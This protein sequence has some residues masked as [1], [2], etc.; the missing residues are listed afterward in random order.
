VRKII[1]IGEHSVFVPGLQKGGWVLDA[2]ANRGRFGAEVSSNFPVRVIQIEPNPALAD[3]LRQQGRNVIGCALGTQDG[4]T[5]LNI[6]TNDEASSIRLPAGEGSHLVVKA[7]VRVA[8]KSLDTIL[9]EIDVQRFAFV[10]L[11]IE[12]AETDVL[13]MAGPA[14]AQI[15]P[16]W[17]VEF[18][19]GDACKICTPAEVDAAI[20]S[21]RNGGFNVLIRNWPSRSNVLFVDRRALSIGPFEWLGIKFRYQYVARLW[22][23]LR[24]IKARIG[25]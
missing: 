16:Q 15:S 6:G 7:S 3:L 11:D 25:K 17:T 19:D 24:G 20:A 1:E 14:A 2:G 18:H 23:I 12:G 10:K 4:S 8:A 9:G 5:V 13:A 21:M 22:R